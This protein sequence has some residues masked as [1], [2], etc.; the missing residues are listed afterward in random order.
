MNKVNRKEIKTKM[1]R[2]MIRAITNKTKKIQLI[3]RKVN[4]YLKS[5]REE[6]NPFIKLSKNNSYLSTPNNNL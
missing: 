1:I 5:K 4:Q 2:K 6:K 3:I